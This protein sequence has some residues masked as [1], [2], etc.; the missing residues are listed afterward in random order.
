MIKIKNTEISNKKAIVNLITI[1]RSVGTVAIIPIF[2]VSGTFSAACAS[3]GLF[4]TDYLDGHLARKYHVESFFGSLLDSLSDKSFGIICLVLLCTYNKAFLSLILSELT[5]FKINYNSTTKN[6]NVKT[7]KLGRIKQGML[8]TT[9]IG[10][11]IC[12]SKDDLKE[13]LT[14]LKLDSFNKLLDFDPKIVTTIMALTTAITSTLV[15]I[16]YYEKSEKQEVE[17][18][19]KLTEFKSSEEIINNL[20]DTDY[21]LEHKND[22]ILSLFKK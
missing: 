20:F 16:D 3:I 14:N 11:F 15:A 5:I 4:F 2:L 1:I 10:S 8:A 22:R 21:Y 19:E 9:I 17:K 12:F 13:I 6:N 18:S 7:S